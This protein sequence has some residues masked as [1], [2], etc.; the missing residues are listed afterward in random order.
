MRTSFLA[1]LW[2]DKAG[3]S[4][5]ELA[6]LTPILAVTLMGVTDV[7][8]AYTRKLA[9]EQAAFRS[10]ERIAGGNV[11]LPDYSFLAAEAATAAGVPVANVTVTN[12]RECNRVTQLTFEGTCPTGEMISQYVRVSIAS[13]YRP[14]FF[15]GPL[16]ATA[17]G[18]GNV[19]LTA[20]A[21][22]RVK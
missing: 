13:S 11:V 4:V 10:L 8:M 20:A 3:T 5:V 16:A 9:L 6:L 2:S 1:R 22:V 15:G 7:S 18:D 14:M 19:A 12:W 17:G 21:S